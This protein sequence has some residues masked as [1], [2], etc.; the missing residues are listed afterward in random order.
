LL[1]F[2][3]SL[4]LFFILT[5]LLSYLCSAPLSVKP[6]GPSMTSRPIRPPSPP[7]ADDTRIPSPIRP[8]S[9]P[10]PNTSPLRRDV[11][12]TPSI[13]LDSNW[14]SEVFVEPAAPSMG[15]SAATESLSTPAVSIAIPTSAEKVVISAPSATITP[16]A[17]KD[18]VP[19]SEASLPADASSKARKT[20]AAKTSSSQKGLVG[21]SQPSIA[22]VLRQGAAPT[23]V[24][25]A[26]AAGTH[27]ALHKS[28]A[29]AVVDQPVR[30][31]VLTRTASGHSLG[32]LV[33][34]ANN[35]NAADQFEGNP[36]NQPF[37]LSDISSRFDHA[38]KFIVDTNKMN[39]VITVSLSFKLFLRCYYML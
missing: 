31:K 32:A 21:S 3:V 2:L 30:G 29:T 13:D 38:A 1:I 35:W 20:V 7:P 37:Q 15:P 24:P 27:L 4:F 6:G 12:E 17:P 34:Y 14:P 5:I 19:T 25:V 23:K 26:S 28:P 8:A 36:M 18:A 22:D 16:A 39:E 11:P 9:P 33:E 10:A